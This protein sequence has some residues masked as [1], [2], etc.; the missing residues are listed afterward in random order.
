MLE[1][2]SD[3]FD[4]SEF[5]KNKESILL[6]MLNSTKGYGKEC[7]DMINKKG[8]EIP[9]DIKNKFELRQ[10]LKSTLIFYIAKFFYKALKCVFKRKNLHVNAELE[11][12]L[13]AEKLYNSNKEFA[14]KCDPEII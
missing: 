2:Y 11:K 6:G 12:D 1:K 10:K 9:A 5:N 3:A 13:N 8:I 14:K 4:L 7:L